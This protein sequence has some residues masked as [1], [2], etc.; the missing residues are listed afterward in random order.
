VLRFKNEKEISLYF[1]IV[2]QLAQV[3]IL[4]GRRVL[5]E[6][7]H[8]GEIMDKFLGVNKNFLHY[9][10]KDE[11]YGDVP[12]EKEQLPKFSNLVEI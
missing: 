3:I 2:D 1:D 11:A 4:K 8:Y 10:C 5:F 6:K 7:E 12:N 9:L